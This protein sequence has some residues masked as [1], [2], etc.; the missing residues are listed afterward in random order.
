MKTCFNPLPLTPSLWEG[1]SIFTASKIILSLFR[2]GP[3]RGDINSTHTPLHPEMKKGKTS[4]TGLVFPSL[5][6]CQDDS[7]PAY[8]A[9]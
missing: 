4:Q 8:T 5:S 2:G 6:A 3:G 1:E 9:T 7:R